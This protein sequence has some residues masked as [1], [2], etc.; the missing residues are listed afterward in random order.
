MYP[1]T[2]YEMTEDDL[3]R[4]LEACKPV[5]YIVIGGHPPRSQQENANAAWAE[6]G[7]RMG[8][9]EMTVQPDSRGTRYFTAISS[10]TEAER[11]QRMALEEKERYERE[12][13]RLQKV[14]ADAEAQLQRL[15]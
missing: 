11:A 6:L 12:R 14:I 8:F 5:P 4:I 3:N 1:R 7:K 15:K 13:E 2:N 9:D 10:E